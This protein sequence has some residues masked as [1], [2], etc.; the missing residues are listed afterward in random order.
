MA[1]AYKTPGVYIEEI[2]RLPPSVAPVETAIPAF[3][4]YTQT[5]QDVVANDLLLIPTRITSLVEYEKHFG[6]PQP[7]TAIKPATAK[8]K[9][10]FRENCDWNMLHILK[11]AQ[12]TGRR[13]LGGPLRRFKLRIALGTVVIP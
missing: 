2:S 5:A 1:T 7:E 4:G 12:W 6:L 8:A 13:W 3:I 11:I 10:N 9:P